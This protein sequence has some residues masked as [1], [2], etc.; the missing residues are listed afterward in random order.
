MQM[1]ARKPDSRSG[2]SPGWLS[3]TTI[4]FFAA[5]IVHLIYGVGAL[6]DKEAFPQGSPQ[7]LDLLTWGYVWLALGV[8]QIAT[9][10]WVRN[11]SWAGQAL[12]M[13]LA[14]LLMIAWFINITYMPFLGIGMVALYGFVLYH[15]SEEQSAF[16]HS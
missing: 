5:G 9:A 4:L 2:E 8:M 13:L 11:R 15:L 6:F 7:F 10:I 3:F 14:G 12:G 1:A 16:V